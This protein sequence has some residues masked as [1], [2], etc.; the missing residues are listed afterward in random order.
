MRPSWW[1]FCTGTGP[2]ALAV[3]KRCPDAEVW[4]T[5]ISEVALGQARANARRLGIA[6]VTFRRRDMYDGLPRRLGA[7]PLR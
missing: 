2:I 1:T 7:E 6:N 5:D 4:G 3:A